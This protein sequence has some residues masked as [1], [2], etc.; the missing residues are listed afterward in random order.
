MQDIFSRYQDSVDFYEKCGRY[1]FIL[2]MS[3]LI[4]KLQIKSIDKT[5]KLFENGYHELQH[6]EEYEEL[7]NMMLE[8]CNNRINKSKPFGLFTKLNYGF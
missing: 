5:I 2:D 4:N 1:I 6:D 7:K 3:L 8:W